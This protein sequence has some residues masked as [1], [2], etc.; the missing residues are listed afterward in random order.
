MAV[1]LRGSSERG[2]RL[3]ALSLLLLLAAT[4][5]ARD[6]PGRLVRLPVSAPDVQVAVA[7]AVK[8]YN[9][10]SAKSFYSRALRVLLASHQ[11]V[12]GSLYY[13][14]IELVNTTCEKNERA[15]LMPADLERCPL[16]PKAEQQKEICKFQI[17]TRSWLSDTRLTHMSCEPTHS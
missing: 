6:V 8:A 16:P 5:Q 15:Q 12:A 7:F 2:A 9:E 17:W 1:A 10:A 3:L 13:L 14:T 4:G 11:M